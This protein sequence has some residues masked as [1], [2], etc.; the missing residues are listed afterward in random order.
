M[1]G[2]LPLGSIHPFSGSDLPGGRSPS[3]GAIHLKL[4]EEVLNKLLALANSN[5]QTD[6]KI[7]LGSNPVSD[8]SPSVLCCTRFGW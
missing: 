1:S 3:R 6:I 5:E 7:D 4:T 2:S 8:L